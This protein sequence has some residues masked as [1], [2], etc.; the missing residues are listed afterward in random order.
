MIL[1]RRDGSIGS[2]ITPHCVDRTFAA[3]RDAVIAAIAFVRAVSGVIGAVQK[4]HVDIFARDVLNRGI[5]FD[6]DRMIGPGNFD[7]LRCGCDIRLHGFT[8]LCLGF[9]FTSYPADFPPSTESTW[10][11]IKDAWSEQR[12]RMALAISSGCPT[13]P[14]GTVETKPAF[15]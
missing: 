2:L 11:L 8:S 12:N 15:L 9:G 3:D 13:R 10:P 14:S 1:D 4:R 5:V 6:R 7:R